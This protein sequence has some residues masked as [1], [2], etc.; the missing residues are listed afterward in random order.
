MLAIAL[1]FGMSPGHC[2]AMPVDS[3]LVIQSQST[4]GLYIEKVQRFLEREMVQ[5][6]LGKMGLSE[7]ATEEYISKLDAVELQQ[8]AAKIDTVEAAK[9][10]GLVVLLV[11]L[12]I[13]MCV[14]YFSDYGVKLE[15]RQK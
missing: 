12:L 3:Q 5:D 2:I 10:N 8:L 11:I 13:A 14:L 15:P 6:H 4:Q 9:G 1:V 7:I